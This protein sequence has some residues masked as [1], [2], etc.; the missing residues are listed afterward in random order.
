MYKKENNE[1]FLA[2]EIKNKKHE[3]AAYVTGGQI[4]NIIVSGLGKA[5][6]E[7]ALLDDATPEWKLRPD[8][9]PKSL[10]AVQL[11]LEGKEIILYDIKDKNE[12]WRLDLTKLLNGISLNL[13]ERPHDA[14]Y[15]FPYMSTVDCIIRYA[16]FGDQRIKSKN[17][18][19]YKVKLT[20]ILEGYVNI[21]ANSIKEAEEIARQKYIFLPRQNY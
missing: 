10:Y 20:Q 4:E 6:I 12:R 11:I 16:L 17:M 2:E 9:M 5:V 13:K 21:T 8:D 1:Y 18:K 19:E 14:N 15:D 3:V 7:W